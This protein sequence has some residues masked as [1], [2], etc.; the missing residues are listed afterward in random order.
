MIRIV[1][2]GDRR[3]EKFNARPAFPEEA[4]KAA[5]AALAEIKARGD[6]AVLEL[7]AKFEGF[8]AKNAKALKVDLSKVSEKGIDSKIVRAVKD[9]HSRVLKFSKA[10]LRGPWSMKSPR[11]GALG[12]FYSPMDRVGVYIPG[13]T[14]PLASTSVMTVTLA[15]AAGVKEIV[16]C[17]PAGAT[18]EVNPVST[19][20]SSPVRPKSTASAAY[21]PSA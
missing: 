20:L 9:A 18:G 5:A 17:T 16:A 2:T 8:K 1:K 21:R 15:K 3:I 14:A 10:S 7:V 13:G 6:A 19:R 11:G 12:E 4:E